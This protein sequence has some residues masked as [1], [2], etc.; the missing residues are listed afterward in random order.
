MKCGRWKRAI[1]WS[2][3]AGRLLRSAYFHCARIAR[4]S[5]QLAGEKIRPARSAGSWSGATGL[6][7]QRWDS[8]PRTPPRPSWK[9]GARCRVSRGCLHR[10]SV[11]SIEGLWKRWKAEER[12]PLSHNP[13]CD[14]GGESLYVTFSPGLKPPFPD[15]ASIGTTEQPGEKVIAGAQKAAEAKEAA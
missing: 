5:M 2:P 6:N 14:Y 13:G 1:Q 3:A 12:F 7:F 11:I 4:N 10:A 15:V 8:T 9:P